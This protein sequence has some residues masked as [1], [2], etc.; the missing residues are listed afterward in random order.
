MKASNTLDTVIPENGRHVVRHYLQ[1][2]GSTFGSGANGPHE[3]DEGW[4]PLYDGSLTRKRLF[5]LGFVFEPWLRADYVDNVAVGR[6]EGERFDP[7]TWS[8]RVPTAAFVRARAD[9]DFWAAR[10]VAAFSD[11]LIRAAVESGGYSDPAAVALLTDVLIKR[12]EKIAQA[13][14]PAINPVVE[15]TLSPAGRLAFRNAAVDAGAGAP[16]AGGYRVTWSE[17]D[18]ATGQSRPLGSPITTSSTDS[19][20][21]TLP[22]AAGA[23]VLAQIAATGASREEWARPIDV[24]FQRTNSGW[25]LIG[26]TRMP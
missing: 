20:A 3:Y 23:I 9:D 22:A 4:E 24:Y 14:L 10:R 8:P 26:L 16:P 5:R 2:V 19:T 17:F 18:N 7:T 21:P 25:R 15:V 11:E 6:F 13:Y 12:R 1:D